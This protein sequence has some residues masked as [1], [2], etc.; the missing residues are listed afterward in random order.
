MSLTS[1]LSPIYSSISCGERLSKIGGLEEHV[2]GLVVMS[3]QQEALLNPDSSVG[4]R[5][6]YAGHG[7]SFLYVECV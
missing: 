4:G 5:H 2:I 3:V 6:S 7:L 1:S